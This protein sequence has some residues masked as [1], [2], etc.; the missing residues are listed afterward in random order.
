MLCRNDTV[1]HRYTNGTIGTV[2]ELHDDNIRVKIP[3][4]E[5]CL[6]R[7]TW[8]IQEYVN[9]VA[10]PGKLELRTIGKFTQFPL[11]LAYAITI[12]KSQGQTW[13]KVCI[14]LSD[15]GAFASGQTYVALSRVK[16]LDGVHLVQKL[17]TSDLDVN[18]RVQKFLTSGEV[19]TDHEAR[20]DECGMKSYWAWCYPQAQRAHYSRKH[21]NE[22][23]LFVNNVPYY[24]FTLHKNEL[25][26][27]VFLICSDLQNNRSLLFKIPAGSET[28]SFELKKEKKSKDR[29]CNQN[30][31]V[32]NRFI[33]EHVDIFIPDEEDNFIELGKQ[34]VNL[35]KYIVAKE[36]E[37]Q[38]AIPAHPHDNLK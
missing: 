2:T 33:N 18:Q 36:V 20:H 35:N 4:G 3:N 32:R 7:A 38:L 14:D 29:R 9:S 1:E 31:N 25:M 37:G 8:E 17:K 24:W 27:D 21:I 23:N 16:T 11:K 19:P 15:G 28:N 13:D 30:A 22:K 10:E 12:H 34:Q 6:Q 5:V 26:E